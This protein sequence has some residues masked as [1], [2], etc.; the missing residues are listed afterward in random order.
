MSKKRVPVKHNPQPHILPKKQEGG[1]IQ[2]E[3]DKAGLFKK[4]APAVDKHLSKG[5]PV[6]N[7]KTENYDTN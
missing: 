2:K 6:T 7:T 5:D 4:P 3:L 1:I